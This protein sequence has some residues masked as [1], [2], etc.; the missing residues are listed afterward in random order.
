MKVAIS[1][2]E[3]YFNSQ[4]EKYFEQAAY[5]VIIDL[6][7]GN[8]YDVI[9]NPGAASVNDSGI[10]MAQMLINFGIDALITKTCNP[11]V[12]RIFNLAGI[13]IFSADEIIVGNIINKL[14][15]EKL[16]LTKPNYKTYLHRLERRKRDE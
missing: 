13:S 1:A 8:G 11:N 5:F 14:K 6:D 4:F 9:C 15:I 7:N 16:N 10:L 12:Q 2:K 3:N